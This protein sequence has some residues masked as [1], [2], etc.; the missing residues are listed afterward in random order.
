MMMIRQQ[1]EAKA[2]SSRNAGNGEDQIGQKE[3][4]GVIEGTDPI[5]RNAVTVDLNEETEVKEGTEAP[6]PDDR[7][8]TIRA[9]REVLT[10]RNESLTLT[11]S[12]LMN[13]LFVTVY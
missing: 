6:V 1:P 3:V 12:K 11:T 7:K 9:G 4:N 2:G 13:C 8:G 10:G 5:G